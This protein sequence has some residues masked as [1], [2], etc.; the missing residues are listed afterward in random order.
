MYKLVDKD[1]A[2]FKFLMVMVIMMRFHFK[3]VINAVK[4]CIGL[5]FVPLRKKKI[6]LRD[7][8]KSKTS[9]KNKIK[10]SRKK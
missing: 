7:D 5:T 10:A 2:E 1:L 9:R 8:G 3:R 6:T 4:Q